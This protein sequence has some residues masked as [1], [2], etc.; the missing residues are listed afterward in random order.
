MTDTGNGWSE[1]YLSELG[2]YLPKD[3]RAEV[4]GELRSQIDESLRTRAAAEPDREPADLELEVL[5]ELGPPHM[6]ADAYVPRPRVLFGPRL[7]PAFFRTLKIA[8]AALTALTALGVY[9]D[10]ARSKSL[11]ALGPALFSALGGLI[12][13]S[14]MVVGI[15]VLV[16]SLIERSAGAPQDSEERWDPRSLAEAQDPAKVALG[17]RISSIAFLVVALI[18]LNFFRHRIGAHLTTDDHSGWIPWLGATFHQYLWLLNLALVLDLL[19]NFI[20]LARWR[21]SLLLRWANFGVNCLYVAFL[22]LLVANPPLLSVDPQWMVENGWTAEA[23]AEYQEFVSGN[24]QRIADINLKFL[25]AIA[26]LGL[27]Y[28]LIKLLRRTIVGT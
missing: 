12:T 26:C 13:G 11:M 20:V 25:L 18:V 17:D 5:G 22:G 19:V 16:F 28:S 15:S 27:A 9:L 23:A 6:V 3:L 14:I 7:Y 10:F 24:F 8:I 2:S 4:V 21:W 1:R